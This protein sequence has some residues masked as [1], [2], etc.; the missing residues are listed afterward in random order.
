MRGPGGC[1][2]DG[3]AG[4]GGSAAGRWAEGREG[5]AGEARGRGRN[6]PASPRESPGT[7]AAGFAL[8]PAR[9][10][11]ALRPWPTLPAP[12]RRP[13]P[14]K[15]HPGKLLCALAARRRRHAPCRPGPASASL[16]APPGRMERGRRPG[17]GQR[18]TPRKAGASSGPGPTVLR[19][20]P[21]ALGR[22]LERRPG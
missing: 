5:G 1:R 4:G 3:A 8:G 20:V 9:P 22:H 6:A 13:K 18:F 21:T 17:L 11:W 14:R 7:E 16:P 12:S 2:H 10:P 19:G 15:S